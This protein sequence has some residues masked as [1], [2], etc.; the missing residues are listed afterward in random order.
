MMPVVEYE[1]GS[2]EKGRKERERNLLFSS[3]PFFSVIDVVLHLSSSSS[4]HFFKR[5]L[6][7][8]GTKGGKNDQ[9]TSV[10]MTDEDNYKLGVFH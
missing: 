5:C 6:K 2:S 9:K 1:W 7:D 8:L 10:V 4:S 3:L